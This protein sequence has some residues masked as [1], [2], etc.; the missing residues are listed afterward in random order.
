MQPQI[1]HI[2]E[3]TKNKELAFMFIKNYCISRIEEQ[4][5]GKSELINPNLDFLAIADIE[6]DLIIASPEVYAKT[7]IKSRF[8]SEDTQNKFPLGFGVV[9]E[10]LTL[11]DPEEIQVS[12]EI[13]HIF[14]KVYSSF[15]TQILKYIKI[16]KEGRQIE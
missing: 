11:K 12:N 3:F 8:Q 7:G 10:G 1:I 4:F 6:N 2:S 15:Y 9:I 16:Y 13:K 5:R 14:S